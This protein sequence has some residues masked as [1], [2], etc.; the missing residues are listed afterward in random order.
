MAKP[1]IPSNREL[2]TTYGELC[3]QA[4]ERDEV[5]RIASTCLPIIRTTRSTD[6]RRVIAVCATP[7]ERRTHVAWDHEFSTT[8]NH[9]R[10]ARR[11]LQILGHTA[12]H[13]L[14][15]GSAPRGDYAFV[16]IPE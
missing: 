10:A 16:L 12:R 7:E 8:E 4:D 13:R 6:G 15:M 14:V 5:R 11:M 1:R 9:A 3:E 2:R